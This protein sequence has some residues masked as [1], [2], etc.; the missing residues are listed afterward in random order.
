MANPSP[1]ARGTPAGIWIPRGWR[2]KFT[3]AINTTVSLWEMTVKPIGFNMG[4]PINQDSMW[5]V[6]HSI[7]RPQPLIVPT[8]GAITF[9]YDPQLESQILAMAGV[10]TTCTQTSYDGGTKAFYGFLNGVE[11]EPLER[12]QPGKGSAEIVQSNWDP[13]N[14]VEVGPQFVF[15]TGS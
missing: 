10:E 6:R 15:V 1:T 8:K 14:F 7:V 9:L 2:T 4:E 12:G 13:V 11:F 5:N 3:F